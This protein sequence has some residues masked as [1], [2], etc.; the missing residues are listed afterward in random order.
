M[1]YC[2]LCPN[3]HHGFTDTEMVSH[4]EEQHGSPVT[5]WMMATAI[6]MGHQEDITS[7][8]AAVRG[9]TMG[10]TAEGKDVE[11]G[12]LADSGYYPSGCR[13]DA[14]SHGTQ[15]VEDVVGSSESR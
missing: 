8:N 2:I 6:R 9:L 7:M 5:A 1:K 11:R 3:N 12:R 15:Q 10:R 13:R 14:G 4:F